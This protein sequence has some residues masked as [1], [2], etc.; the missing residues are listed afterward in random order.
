ML[1]EIKTQKALQGLKRGYVL[2]FCPG[3]SNGCRIHTFNCWHVDRM[4]LPPRKIWANTVEEL[5]AWIAEQGVK[6]DWHS[7]HCMFV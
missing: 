4:T 2:N 1:R 7:P 3:F 5:E 6:L